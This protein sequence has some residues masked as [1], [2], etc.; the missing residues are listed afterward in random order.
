MPT[1]PE[2]SSKASQM[3]KSKDMDQAMESRDSSGP[4]PA[5]EA[6]GLPRKTKDMAPEWW[7][8]WQRRNRGN[9]ALL[10]TPMWIATRLLE[11]EPTVSIG[12][13]CI[14]THPSKI[15]EATHQRVQDINRMADQEAITMLENLQTQKYVQL[16]GKAGKLTM[17]LQLGF[18]GLA[19]K[20]GVATLLDSG[21]D[22]SSIDHHFVKRNIIPTK[23]V[24]EQHKC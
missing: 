1:A 24:A 20:I 3:K 18:L 13:L 15:N 4:Y 19:G 9:M 17:G 22:G 7:N 16:A 21:C 11:E 23:R 6:A 5:S 14:W 12:L 8:S 2:G 10:N